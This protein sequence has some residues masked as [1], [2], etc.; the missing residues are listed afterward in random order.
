MTKVSEMTRATLWT[1]WLSTCSNNHINVSVLAK[2]SE[3][4]NSINI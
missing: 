4:L 1:Q 3:I 2:S